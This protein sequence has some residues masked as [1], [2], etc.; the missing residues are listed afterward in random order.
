MND[1]DLYAGR[2]RRQDEPFD[3]CPNCGRAVW[4]A[5][6]VRTCKICRIGLC[7]YCA[8]ALETHQTIHLYCIDCFNRIYDM[9]GPQ[10][11]KEGTSS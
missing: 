5:T 4:L 1:D 8:C 6:E 9:D 11:P 3:R 10:D 7:C 2:N